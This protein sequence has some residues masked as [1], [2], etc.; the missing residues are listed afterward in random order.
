WSLPRQPE[1][2]LALIYLVTFGSIGLFLL[3]LTV[4]R[5]W[6]ASA[7][8]YMFV[9]FPVA[10]MTLEAV[11]FGEPITF[12]AAAA[13]IVMT[14]VWIGALAPDLARPARGTAPSSG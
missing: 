1:A 10:T 6:T 12:S 13:A 7:T 9:L 4:I 3:L 14:G 8:S 5:R 2:A 11:L